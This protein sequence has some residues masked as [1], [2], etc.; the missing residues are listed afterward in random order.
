MTNLFKKL[1]NQKSVT[2]IMAW[3]CLTAFIILMLPLSLSNHSLVA[4]LFKQYSPYLW[5]LVLVSGSF[6]LTQLVIFLFDR[7][8]IQ[9]ESRNKLQ[10]RS[11]MIKCL[12]FEEK[13]VLRE[14]VIQKKN[15]LSLPLTEPAVT[16]LL[17]A[18]V[19]E[20][21]FETQEIKGKACLI[22]LS[23]AIGARQ[24]LTHRVLGLPI[25]ELTEDQAKILKS[26]RPSYARSNYIA[27][28]D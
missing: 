11:H 16:N 8:A 7:L 3:I 17:S 22:K 2:I 9:V 27:L 19:L 25:G 1:S 14:F 21:A 28:R 13:A 4:S 10:S 12:D 18:G 15:V 5:I 26:A 20:P 24:K 23:I 6:L